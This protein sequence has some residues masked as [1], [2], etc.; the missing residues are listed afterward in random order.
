M[1]SENMSMI[2]SKLK[3][4]LADRETADIIVFGSF[5][6]GKANPNDIDIAVITSKSERIEIPGFHVSM[7]KPKDFFI[8]PPSIVHTLL[9]EGYSLRNNKALS[10]LYK[11]SS[12]ALFRYELKALNLSKKVRAVNML[13][14]KSG[15]KGIVEESGGEWLANNVFLLPVGK[16]SLL[17]RFFTENSIKFKKHYV[18]I[19]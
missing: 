13:R 14:G 2:K 10:E 4:Y 5:A 17:E 11:F 12:R 1:A 15:E 18:L 19:H 9:R 7:L 8:N 6:K 16:D 3:K